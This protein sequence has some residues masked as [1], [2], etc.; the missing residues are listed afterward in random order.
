[1]FRLLSAYY[2]CEVDHPSVINQ[3]VINNP[4]RLIKKWIKRYLLADN[5]VYLQNILLILQG[6]LAFNY[7]NMTK[8][9]LINIQSLMNEYFD[10][11]STDIDEIRIKVAE[12]RT[13]T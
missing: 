3:K 11:Q 7:F 8:T 9:V 10:F 12:L 5:S 2:K 1:M 13:I 4:N 6:Y